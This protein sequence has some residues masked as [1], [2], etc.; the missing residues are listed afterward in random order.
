LS[1]QAEAECLT[2]ILVFLCLERRL[3]CTSFVASVAGDQHF[4]VIAI[5]PI[6]I[7]KTRSL[8]MPDKE[9]NYLRAHFLKPYRIDVVSNE[10]I[11]T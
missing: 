2:G 6:D 11:L 8:H 10:V 3:R 4:Y 5:G 9:C 1:T 7:A